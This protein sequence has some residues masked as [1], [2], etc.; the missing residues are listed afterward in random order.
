VVEHSTVEN[1][2]ILENCRISGIKHLADSV[3]GRNTILAGQGR[4]AEK[5]R[6]LIGDDCRVELE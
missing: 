3:I 1:S 4:G 6:L 2:V 5:V